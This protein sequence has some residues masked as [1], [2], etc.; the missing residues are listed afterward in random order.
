MPE[1]D[2]NQGINERCDFTHKLLKMNLK[3]RRYSV[4]SLLF[5]ILFFCLLFSVS[6]YSKPDSIKV[7]DMIRQGKDLAGKD[8]IRSI[9]LLRNAVELA[10]SLGLEN[11]QITAVILTIADY[12]TYHGKLDSAIMLS[13]KA[14][15]YYETRGRKGETVQVLNRIGDILRANSMYTNS[16]IYFRQALAILKDHPDSTLLASVFNRLAASFYEDKVISLDSAEKYASR[17]LD[18]SRKLNIQKRIFNNLNI[19]GS[20]ESKRGNY[21]KALDYYHQALPILMMVAPHEEPLILANMSRNYANLSELRKAE[22]LSR[23][24]LVLSEK[25]GI[26]QYEL[27]ASMNL[28]FIYRK[29]GDYRR[30]LEYQERYTQIENKLLTQRVLVQ[31]QDFNHRSEIDK[32][33]NEKRQ[34]ELEQ[35]VTQHRLRVTYLLAVLLFIILI[36]TAAF[37]FYQNQQ[38]KKMNLLMEKLDQS[39]QVLKRFISIVAHD[40]RS[41]FNS[42]L[43]FS[44]LLRS[45]TDL[46]DEERHEAIRYLHSA[47]RSTFNLL[48]RL[49]EWSRLQ[50]GSIQPAKK[51]INLTDHVRETL[52]HLEPQARMKRISLDFREHRQHLVFADPDMVLTAIRN[53]VSNAIKFTNPGGEVRVVL[54]QEGGLIR[55]SVIDNGVGMEEK[56]VEKLFRIEENFKSKGTAGEQGTGLGLILCRDYI[57]MN[58]GKLLVSSEPGKGS[59]FTIEL[60]YAEQNH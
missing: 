31:V 23:R 3:K 58:G 14:L 2:S 26:P 16:Y 38:R 13:L 5:C 29:M 10:G 59:T 6:A 43:G 57:E 22:E 39:N 49:L 40:L 30:A 42:I 60:P 48:E 50:S 34:L 27:M 35:K 24:A 8:E 37:L 25:Y 4:L 32:Q 55:L 36:S 53:L 1:P 17:S 52:V 19:L 54:M 47:S 51:E 41:P 33:I 15:K 28:T 56:V 12:D 44:E 9:G 18:I 11:D 21:R 46:S 7:Y 45:E 20:I